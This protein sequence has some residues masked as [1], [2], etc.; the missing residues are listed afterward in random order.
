MEIPIKTVD[1]EW[2]AL[3]RILL[4]LQQVV[5]RH[6]QSGRLRSTSVH[7]LTAL[8]AHAAIADSMH[9][10]AVAEVVKIGWRRALQVHPEELSR[11]NMVTVHSA[12]AGVVNAGFLAVRKAMRNLGRE[13][14]LVVATEIN[15]MR[16][17]ALKI[18]YPAAWIG[19]FACGL[20]AFA[21]R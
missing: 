13:T 11:L 15:R 17:E 1:G 20:D 16:R 12:C 6:C 3:G 2:S 7:E 9:V 4:G 14:N 5:V 18:M 19:E 10:G 8:Q 21:N